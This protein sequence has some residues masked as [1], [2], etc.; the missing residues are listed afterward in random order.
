MAGVVYFLGP[1]LGVAA[2]PFFPPHDRG[3]KYVLAN[4][5]MWGMYYMVLEVAESIADLNFYFRP[6][7]F[8]IIEIIGIIGSIIGYFVTFVRKVVGSRDKD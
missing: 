3:K 2:T 7:V 4:M 8:E 6:L 5:G 1:I